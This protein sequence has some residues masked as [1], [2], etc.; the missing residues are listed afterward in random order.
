MINE[1]YQ[2]QLEFYSR[3]F[4]L[5]LCHGANGVPPIATALYGVLGF[6]QNSLDE[7]TLTPDLIGM[8]YA[9]GRIPVSQGY[10]EVDYQAGKNAK[11]TVLAVC[12]V[13]VNF[14]GR[15][16]KYTKPG[17]YYL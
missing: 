1:S 7:Y 11:V 14:E 4:G 15:T 10:I 9:S 8:S 12:T 16:A 6:Q 13:T 3:P 5:S 2:K 17:T